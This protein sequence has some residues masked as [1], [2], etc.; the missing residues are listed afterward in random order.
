MQFDVAR[1]Q[2]VK[3]QIRTWEVLD[4][5]VIDTLQRLPRERFVPDAYRD[6][7]FAD[8][9]IPLGHGEHMLPPKIVGRFL[10]AL[11]LGERDSV[12]E[13][14]SGSGYLT[15]AMAMQCGRVRSI[16]RHADFVSAARARI[17]SLGL[18]STDFAVADAFE[19]GALGGGSWDAVVLTG[20]LPVYDTRFEQR[21]AVGGRLLVVI[22]SAPVME[23]TLVRRVS[24]IEWTRQ[25]L[26][27]TVIDPLVGA[28]TAPAF[29][30]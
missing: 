13:V 16:D 1:E 15:A 8:S 29:R 27:E 19:P 17:A 6:A 10:Q 2:M 7:A 28:P 20:S 18:G 21:L 11:D 12:L 24:A 22:G 23:A 4:D 9:A 14:G 3:Q 26:F 25:G 30:F 5:R